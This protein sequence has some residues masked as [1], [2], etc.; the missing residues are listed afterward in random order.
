MKLTKPPLIDCDLM[1]KSII[2]FYA[3]KS[4]TLHCY[5]QAIGPQTPLSLQAHCF[6]V[7]YRLQLWV[8][9]VVSR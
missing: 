5:R 8:N 1:V 6:Y 4:N 2:I 3:S 9:K 7:V